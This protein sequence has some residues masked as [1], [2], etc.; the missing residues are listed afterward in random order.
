MRRNILLSMLVAILVLFPG[1]GSA[2]QAPSKIAGLTL[3]EKIANF[4]QLVQMETAMPIRY[5][6]YLR[7]VQ[8]GDLD[9]YK[10]GT[11]EF[12][13][14]LAPGRIVRIKLKYEDPE[15]KFFNELLKR[16]KKKFGEPD[17]WRGD[18]FHVIMAWKWSF[19][20]KDNNSISLILQHSMDEEQKFGNSVKLTNTT[21]VEKERLCYERKHPESAESR[22][23]KSTV[24]KKLTE[25]DYQ[26]FIPE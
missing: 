13:D 1:P 12:G 3:G 23:S 25:A 19:R 26:R 17:E 16:F 8:T 5:Q 15:K 4:V 21:F 14:C 9:G 6:E 24:K 10:S 7:V 18:P 2:D 20:D 22:K 11:V